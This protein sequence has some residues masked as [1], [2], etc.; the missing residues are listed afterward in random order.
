MGPA[1]LPP[2]PDPGARCGPGRV[3]VRGVE[4]QFPIR[5]ALARAAPTLPT[6][7][8]WHFEIKLDGHRMILRRTEDA[9][10][11][12][13]RTG[14]TVTSH[15]MDLAVPATALP[16][17][18]VL[19]GEAVIWNAGAIDFGA[20]QAR[21]ASSLDRA[22]ALAARLPAAYAAF[23]VPG[24]PR[25]RRGHSGRPPSHR[26]P[27]GPGRRPG[28][29]WPPAAT[30]PGHRR[31]GHRPPLVRETPAPGGRGHP[32]PSRSPART[33]SAPGPCGALTAPIC[34]ACK[35]RI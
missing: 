13:S 25:P 12:Y 1:L 33:R 3:R 7:P 2:G 29:R 26:A 32:S 28:P 11:C 18:T 23:D 30:R 31:P 4:F 20:V 21:A 27:H 6:G 10:V 34:E 19:D 5:P 9:V 8:T 15:W 24:P 35:P 17:G 16:P 14:R 22:R